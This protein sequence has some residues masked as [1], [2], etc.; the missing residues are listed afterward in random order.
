MEL[1]VDWYTHELLLFCW[2]TIHHLL[3]MDVMFRN[4]V[5]FQHDVA[6]M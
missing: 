1:S 3:F 4:E 6:G 5:V 2:S